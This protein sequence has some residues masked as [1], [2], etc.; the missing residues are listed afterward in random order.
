M[1]KE[2]L[3][4]VNLSKH[5]SETDAKV[6]SCVYVTDD[7]QRFTTFA[8]NRTPDHAGQI[9]KNMI[10]NGVI[11][12]PIVCTISPKFP[13]K[14]VIVDGGNTFSARMQLG[15]PIY[16][17]LLEN[18]TEKDMSTLNLVRKNWTKLDY[19]NFYA[20]LGYQEYI[21]F[22]QFLAEFTDFTAS[23][24]EFVLQL[25][26]AQKGGMVGR[27]ESGEFVIK[28]VAQSRVVLNFLMKVKSVEQKN[29]VQKG[30]Y[31][32]TRRSFLV[33]L[34]NL[35]RQNVIEL[36]ELADRI[37]KYKMMFVPQLN[38]ENY[39]TMIEKIYNRNRRGEYIPLRLSNDAGHYYKN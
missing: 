19:I 26:A 18:A 15:L 28:N 27:L 21:L 2:N 1:E 37:N 35:F 29:G 25:S 31:V 5:E 17:I 10:D 6:V 12:V 20:S 32:F 24:M 36:D 33:C 4:V 38:A 30:E 22:K 34:L 14:L 16:Y 13:K 23:T 11:S 7:Y 3:R 8:G 9:M 39:C